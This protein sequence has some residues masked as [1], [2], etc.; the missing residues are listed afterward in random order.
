MP[1]VA[2]AS[3]AALALDNV[4]PLVRE[5]LDD[6]EVS[7]VATS[8]G[9]A[10]FR[11]DARSDHI[12][13]SANAADILGLPEEEVPATGRLLQR[14]LTPE[15]ATARATSVPP[16]GV[17]GGAGLPPANYRVVYQLKPV[18]R[19]SGPRIVEEVGRWIAGSDG[20]ALASEGCIRA[21][22]ADTVLPGAA[23]EAVNPSTGLLLRDS[24]LARLD[25]TV[26]E[27]ARDRQGAAAF[28]V[29]A[30]DDLAR[31]NAN[32]GYEV[33][34]RIIATVAQ[35]I[36]R[37][38]RQGDV[39]G[40]ISGHKFGAILHNC[41]ETSLSF[42]A[43]RFRN[44]VC[45]ELIVTQDAEIQA[46]VSIGAV[47]VP[48]HAGDAE[49]AAIR[50]EEALAE[51]R[52]DLDTGFK[53]YHPSPERDLARRRNL[54]I[55]EDI[56]RGLAEHR[57][58]LAYQPLI[59]ATTREIVS[60]EALTRLIRTDGTVVSAGPLIATAERLGL[61]RRIDLHALKLALAD[62]AVNPGLRLSVNV[63]VET[64]TDPAWLGMLV[65]AVSATR[66]IAARLTIEITETAA[67]RNAEEMIRLYEILRDIGCRVAI[68]D[69]GSGH[70]SFKA[71]RDM[72]VDWVKI[73]GAYVRDLASNPDSAIFVK[74]LAAL[75]GH[76]RIRT[77]AEWVQDAESADILRDIGVHALQ[78]RYVGEPMLRVTDDTRA[79][80]ESA[81]ALKPT[82]EA[83]GYATYGGLL[84]GGLGVGGRAP[85]A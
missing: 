81:M 13:W 38:M 40:H 49:T 78:G 70:T 58:V 73:D 67:M 18:D 68:D 27:L 6:S 84:T 63:S 51:A 55:A 52:A 26:K 20:C 12:A 65:D 24:L 23:G 21:L 8:L 83:D 45:S 75:A 54:E 31:L 79:V 28:L 77:V 10:T 17:S 41:S 59:D 43:D 33:G 76:F 60:Y 80:I 53:I 22:P 32:F 7:A 39:L 19:T 34:D 50:A 85:A 46:S 3:G 72:E 62:L 9:L 14:L 71:L 37:R 25:S 1:I 5:R 57:F 44:A 4:A 2:E 82:R 16:V 74:T 35:R 69:F 30:V 11:W 47:V 29:V 48:R 15:T 36:G 42:A 56:V 61:V 64:V 66:S